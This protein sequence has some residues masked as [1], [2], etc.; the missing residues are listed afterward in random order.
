MADYCLIGKRLNYSY[1]KV[2]HNKLG[3]DYDL[4]EVKEG[5]LG[6][7]V[8]ARKYKGFNVT[9][10]YKSA[11]IE[12]LD[13]ITDEAKKLGV[14]NLVMDEG[15]KLVGYNM[16]IRGME[17][18]LERSG[19]S[20]AGKKVLILGTGNTSAT[21]AY[22]AEKAGAKEIVKISRTGENTYEN[23]A[24]H[25]DAS[26]IINT[27]PVGTYPSNEDC[28]LDLSLFPDLEGV[29][30]V[31]YNPFKTRLVL[32]AEARSLAVATGLDMLVGQAYCTAEKFT[33]RLPDRAV[34]DRIVRE[35]LRDDG[36]IVLVGMPSCGKT[37][38][39]RALAASLGRPFVDT[40]EEIVKAHGD[41]PTIFA[42][43]GE[44]VF[45]VYESEVIAEVGKRHGLV[46]ATGGGAVKSERNILNLKQNG[47]VVYVKRDLSELTADGRPL[48]QNGKI[49][50][51]YKERAPIYER[52]ADITVMN[53]ASISDAV[54]AILKEEEKPG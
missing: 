3:Y 46:I 39:G 31:I 28:L 38:I 41:I 20:L 1:S 22:L 9:I 45:R 23:I 6:T 36:N 15:G 42:A 35:I 10:P 37:T 29:Q 34:V 4:T 48:S 47:T 40:D 52:I 18:A 2:V 13:R 54:G 7:F 53:D 24:R 17:Y 14:V 16:D 12:Y 21:A 32:Q 50:A 19:V 26:F 43:E 30:E 5:E 27:T 51:L 49:A 11:I 25:R 44:A 8:R 33:G